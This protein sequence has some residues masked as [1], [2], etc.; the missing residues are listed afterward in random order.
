AGGDVRGVHGGAPSGRHA[1]ADQHGLLQRQVVID[2]DRR[3][4][5]D[6]TVLAEGPDHAH[7]AVL[8]AGPGDGEALTGQVAL[9]DRRAHVADRL[10]AGGAVAA[11]TAVRDER[12]DDVITWRHARHAHPDLLDDPGAFVAQHH[13]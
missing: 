2:L 7:G 10:A 5:A 9:Q 13:G 11:D 1:A 6:H 12:A 4:L 3:G 8:A